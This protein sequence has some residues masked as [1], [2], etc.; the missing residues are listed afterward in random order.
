MTFNILIIIREPG[1]LTFKGEFIHSFNK[2]QV[3]LC[4]EVFRRPRDEQD[5]VP[6]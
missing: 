4:Q 5:T 2:F 3:G 6:A 1:M